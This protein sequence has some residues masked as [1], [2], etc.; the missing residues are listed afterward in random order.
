MVGRSTNFVW[1][2][3]FWFPFYPFD[4]LLRVFTARGTSDFLVL[5]WESP[6]VTPSSLGTTRTCC[7]SARK[8]G[9]ADVKGGSRDNSSNIFLMIRSGCCHILCLLPW[10]KHLNLLHPGSSSV[11][12]GNN[13]ALIVAI[14]CLG[15]KIVFCY[16]YAECLPPQLLAWRRQSKTELGSMGIS[17]FS[18]GGPAFW[19]APLNPH[20]SGKGSLPCKIVFLKIASAL[21]KQKRGAKKSATK[22]PLPFCSNG[23][24]IPSYCSRSD[25][26][27][28]FK[29]DWGGQRGQRN[30]SR[31]LGWMVIRVVCSRQRVNPDLGESTGS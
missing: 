3:L 19:A 18:L 7:C 12:Q 24:N 30:Q 14:S 4:A 25:N 10:A 20:E 11:K 8:A 2:P 31:P 9:N 5:S 1:K 15:G 6:S 13:S 26:N 21:P 16:F 22:P 27:I 23:F 28:K 17:G 29:G